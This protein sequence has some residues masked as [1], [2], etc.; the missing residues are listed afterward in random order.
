MSSTSASVIVRWLEPG[1]R[2]HQQAPRTRGLIRRRQG[3]DDA[4]DHLWV[5]GLTDDATVAFTAQG[6][7]HLKKQLD[8]LKG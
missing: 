5:L 3:D 4:R 7:E 2:P 6:I 1:H 8:D